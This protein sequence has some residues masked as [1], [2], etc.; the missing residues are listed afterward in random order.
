LAGLGSSSLAWYLLEVTLSSLPCLPQHGSLLRE[1]ERETAREKVTVLCLPNHRNDSP[2]CCHILLVK[3]NYSRRK[4]NTKPP[5]LLGTIGIAI[6]G[7]AYHGYVGG[8]W[9]SMQYIDLWVWTWCRSQDPGLLA[10]AMIGWGLRQVAHRMEVSEFYMWED[11]N[12]GDQE[13]KL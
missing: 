6:L 7:A 4:D 5:I 3:V 12:S 9:F 2:Q 8:R 10:G 11:V 13:E 1:T